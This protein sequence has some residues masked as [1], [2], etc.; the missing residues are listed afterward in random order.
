MMEPTLAGGGEG[1]E[2]EKDRGEYNRF[3]HYWTYD[4]NDITLQQYFL[5]E[6]KETIW[7]ISKE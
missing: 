2:V 4:E 7:K 3:S 1:R 6:I 5:F